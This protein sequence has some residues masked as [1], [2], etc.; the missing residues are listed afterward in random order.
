[1]LVF[2]VS[3]CCLIATHRHTSERTL[4]PQFDLL[5]EEEG[6]LGRGREGIRGRKD[7]PVFEVRR[8]LVRLESGAATVLLVEVES[9]GGRRVFAPDVLDRKRLGSASAV[10]VGRDALEEL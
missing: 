5:L 8:C 10:R 7:L 6:D 3:H 1:M 2:V 9:V 4:R